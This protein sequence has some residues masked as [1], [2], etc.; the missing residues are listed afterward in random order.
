MSALKVTLTI[1]AAT[2][3]GAVLGVRYANRLMDE[4]LS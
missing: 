4:V 2:A 1:L 3:V